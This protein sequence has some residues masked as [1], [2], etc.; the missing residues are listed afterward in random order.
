MK[1]GSTLRNDL[2]FRKRSRS[3]CKRGCT[4]RNRLSAYWPSVVLWR[5]RPLSSTGYPK[6][7]S[8]SGLDAISAS[9]KTS[10]ADSQPCFVKSSCA[11]RIFLCRGNWK[12]VRR[13]QVWNPVLVGRLRFQP[14]GRDTWWC[15]LG[16]Y[17][18]QEAPWM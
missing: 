10:D 17:Y 12:L 14:V 16:Q 15:G 6:R 3:L 7:T 4:D 5:H 1:H 8:P 18:A 2:R 11:L 9:S 13:R